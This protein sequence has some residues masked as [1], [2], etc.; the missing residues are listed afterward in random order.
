MV[1]ALVVLVHV[2]VDLV[3]V[4]VDL[5]QAHFPQGG[6][7]LVVSRQVVVGQKVLCLDGG[8]GFPKQ[9]FFQINQYYY[10]YSGAKLGVDRICLVGVCEGVGM[11]QIWRG[12]GVGL[13]VSGQNGGAGQIVTHVAPGVQQWGLML[14]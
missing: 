12:L 14:G 13:V 7:L 5:V 9:G 4:F 2:P 8:L 10:Y 3:Q 6:L 11:E 1:C